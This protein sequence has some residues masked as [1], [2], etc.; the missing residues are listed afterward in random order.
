M[1]YFHSNVFLSAFGPYRIIYNGVGGV[2]KIIMFDCG[3]GVRLSGS[4][5]VRPL[6]LCNG[7]IGLK[8]RI[9]FL[10]IENEK[11]AVLTH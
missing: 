3:C 10:P 9:Q 5:R 7:N 4:H 6:I 1:Y 2:H 11:S 8:T